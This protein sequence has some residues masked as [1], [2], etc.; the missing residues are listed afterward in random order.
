MQLIYTN[1]HDL[2]I[3]RTH[4]YIYR[5]TP[6]SCRT[7]DIGQAAISRQASRVNLELKDQKESEPETEFLGYMVCG[8]IRICLHSILYMH[9]STYTGEND[10]IFS[11]LDP[12]VMGTL[13]HL[14]IGPSASEAMR[15]EDVNPLDGLV[16][17]L[18]YIKNMLDDPK[19]RG[20]VGAIAPQ[21]LSIFPTENTDLENAKDGLPASSAPVSK[22][23]EVAPVPSATPVKKPAFTP[24]PSTRPAKEAVKT[25]LGRPA[26]VDPPPAVPCPAAATE[27][28]QGEINSSTHRAA[29][30]RLVREMERCDEAKFPH[31]AKLWQGSRKDYRGPKS[32]SFFITLLMSIS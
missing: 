8:G 6:R 30:A 11:E 32:F 31:M 14:R 9:C 1:T 23:S 12:V 5:S 17:S 10:F 3:K 19:M 4:I 16:K 21:L 7:L 13:Y 22:S 27:K 29:H 24:L 26:P 25:E 28:P 18:T 2:S 20:T 15:P